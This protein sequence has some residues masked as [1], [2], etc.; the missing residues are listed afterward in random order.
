VGGRRP[1]DRVVGGLLPVA[2]TLFGGFL[3]FWRL[4]RPGGH[5]LTTDK[6]IVFDET[7]YA[8]DSWSLLHHGV[9]TNGM[10]NGPGFVVH[11]SLGKWLIA[12]GEAAVDHGHQVV[13]HDTIYPASPLS[14][15]I[16][17]A[18][19]GTLTILLTCRIGRR[20]FRSTALGC[21]AGVLVALDGLELVQSRTSM[22]DIFLGFW[23][24]A[25]VGALLLDRDHGRRKLADRLT[26][27]ISGDDRGPTLGLRPW[28]IAAGLFIGFACGTKWDGA[29]WIPALLILGFCWDVSARRTAGARRPVRAAVVRDG[30]WSLA[31]FVLL[32]AVVYVA[33]WTGWF[34]S[35]GTYAFDHDRYTHAG[36]SW[37]GHDW[38]VVRGWWNYQQQIWHYD[39]T[40]NW[41][42]SPHPY[43]SRPYGWLILS[44][45]VAY[46]YQSNPTCGATSC[47][48]EVLAVGNPM[49]W[50]ASIPALVACLWVWLTRRDWRAGALLVVFGVG[51]LPWFREDAHQR[52]MFLFYLL[53][54]VPFMAMA[55]ALGLGLIIGPLRV[56]DTRRAVG[57][58]IAG[59]YLALVT[60][61]A[62]WLYPILTGQSISYS[63][64]HER[65]LYHHCQ[66][67]P[68]THTEN[69][70]CWI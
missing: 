59:A 17:G 18:I 15:R 23:V 52:V 1:P 27:P 42:T 48:Q 19:I 31:P 67:K 2:I 51:Y 36:Q 26:A 68:D 69:A 33:S 56:S 29:Y 40:L 37:L 65:M 16:S 28:R 57:I 3:R 6:S 41:V 38:S 35:N 4:T 70:L 46:Y 25:S 50:W 61:F 66:T 47:S 39:D 32:P 30:Y 8:H 62:A 21:I 12:L 44:R 49:L 7:Y 24:L 60:V 11:P 20:L 22:L 55:V 58:T 45:P 13:F 43:L 53:P 9:E 10:M 63:A 5:S 34:L 54:V 64:W 14:F